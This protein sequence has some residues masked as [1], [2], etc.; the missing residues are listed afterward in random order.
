MIQFYILID[1][2]KKHFV[3]INVNNNVI[4]SF[5]ITDS[6]LFHDLDIVMKFQDELL[7]NYNMKFDLISI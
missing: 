5:D 1:N 2:S 3:E 7:I 4:L 6:M